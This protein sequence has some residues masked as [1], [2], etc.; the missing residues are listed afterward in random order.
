MTPNFHDTERGLETVKRFEPQHLNIDPAQ[1]YRA[2][3]IRPDRPAHQRW[4]AEVER[5]IQDLPRLT[6]PRG[7]FRVDRVTR[8]EGRSLELG[9]GAR[10]RGAVGQFLAH[11]EY[12]A[13][14]V[15]TIGSAAERLARRWMKGTQ[16]MRG[17][18]VDAVAS[19]AAE[20][21]ADQLQHRV[22]SLAQPH[23]LDVTPRYSPGYCGM[24]ITEQ[25]QLFQTLPVRDVGVHLTPSCLMMPFKS[26]SGLIGLAPAEKVGPHRYPCE[27]CAHPDCMQRRA[28]FDAQNCATR[29]KFAWEREPTAPPAAE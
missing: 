12:V 29:V 26:V 16:I 18:I 8:L 23:G 1:V 4:L 21:L 14:F 11:A 22:Q 15:V 3:G 17:A 19:E 9:S 5:C 2:V 7:V 27:F 10:Y 20:N 25:Q 6:R 24:L 28:P 13:T